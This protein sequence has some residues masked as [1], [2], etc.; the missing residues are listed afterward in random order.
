MLFLARLLFASALVVGQ[1]P[2]DDLP[3]FDAHLHYNREAWGLYS[4]DEVLALLDQAGVRKAFVS[5]T[6]DE[7]TLMLY[8]RAPERI[9]PS[10]RPYRTPIDQATFARDPSIVPY[11]AERLAERRYRGIGEFHLQPGD[12]AQSAPAAFAAFGA[13]SGMVLHVHAGAVAL[14]EFLDLRADDS[15][16]WAHAGL[17][18]SPATVQRILETYPNVWVELALRYDV[19]PGGRLDPAWAALFQRYPDRFMI[20]TDTWI[21]SQWTRLP[22]LMAD[23]RTWLRQL[24]PD[25]ATAIAYGNAERLL[26]PAAQ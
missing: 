25:L 7:G 3:I 9:V 12:A 8:D 10:L 18:E 17:S 22:G 19:A 2:A 24:P 16:L 23:V 21:P 5:S 20:G 15:V 14:R 1:V 4:V 6:P 26:T 11:V 13:G